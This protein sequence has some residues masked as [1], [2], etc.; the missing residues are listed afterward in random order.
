MNSILEEFKRALQILFSEKSN[1]AVAAIASIAAF[2][3]FLSIPVLV[4]PGNDYAFQLSLMT[5]QDIIIYIILA[6]ITGLVLT[7][8]F[9]IFKHMR[10]IKAHGFTGIFSSAVASI[11]AIK[12]CPMCIA[13]LFGLFGISI[14]TGTALVTHRIEIAIL[15]IAIAGVS[16]YYSCKSIGKCE[17]C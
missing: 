15:S 16:L 12:V 3:F 9:Y 7:M 5:P 13:G 6:L 11:F 2:I 1:L 4:I 10:S 17:S 8:Q 14:G